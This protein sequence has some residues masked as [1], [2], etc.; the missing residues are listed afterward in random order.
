LTVRPWPRPEETHIQLAPRGRGPRS[1]GGMISGS[2]FGRSGGIAR[3]L[4]T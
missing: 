4:M 1:P 2:T 3:S